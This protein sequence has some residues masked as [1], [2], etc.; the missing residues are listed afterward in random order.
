MSSP[1]PDP[2]QAG[3]AAGWQVIDASTLQQD[4]SFDADVVVIGTGAGGAVVA[5]LLQR[6]GYDQ[7]NRRVE[8]RDYLS[9]AVFNASFTQYDERGLVR[10][11]FQLQETVPTGTAVLSSDPGRET[12][13]GYDILGNK[14]QQ[15]DA[16][17]NHQSW[18]YNTAADGTGQLNFTVGRLNS[19]T[20]TSQAGDLSHATAYAYTDF[21]QISRETY[22]GTDITDPRALNDATQN[23]RR[24]VYKDN[25]LLQQTSDHQMVGKEG[26]DGGLD[27]WTSFSTNTYSYT[28]RGLVSIVDV[29]TTGQYEDYSVYGRVI[30]TYATQEERRHIETGYDNQDRVVLVLNNTNGANNR[31]SSEVRYDYDELGNRT[32]I[33]FDS[34]ARTTQPGGNAVNGE[35]VNDRQLWFKY[36][37]DGRMTLANRTVDAQEGIVKDP[38]VVITYDAAGRRATALTFEGG[39]GLDGPPDQDGQTHEV[40]A[41][42]QSRLERYTYNDLGYLTK[43]EQAGLRTDKRRVDGTVLADDAG[44]SAFQLSETRSYDLLGN[45]ARSDQYYHFAFVSE[46]DMALLPTS[47][48]MTL[49][50]EY[51]TAGLLEVQRTLNP[52]ASWLNTT[53]TNSYENG[54]LRS[55]TYKKGDGFGTNSTTGYTNTYSYGY[56]F[57][58]GALREASIRVVS[59]LRD[60]TV[61][62]KTDTYD[63]RG[64]LVWHRTLD[65]RGNSE[66]TFFYYDGAGRVLDKAQF[67]FSPDRRLLTGDRYDTYFY[68]TGGEAIGDVASSSFAAVNALLHPNFSTS[69]TPVS[70]SYPGSQPGT[71]VVSQG[72]TLAA[73]ARSFL[74]DEQLWYL[75]A[76]A[77]GLSA[78][79]SEAL[80]GHAGRALRIPNVV[81][82][83]HNNAG[84]FSPYNPNTIIPSTPWIGAPLPPPGLTA[85]EQSA[86]SIA[87]IVG[88]AV[89][90]ALGIALG[91]GGAGLGVALSGAIGAAAG[92]V[93]QQAVQL[94]FGGGGKGLDDFDLRAPF[95]AFVKAGVTA[96]VGQFAA[97]IGGST[98]VGQVLARTGG[99]AASYAINGMPDHEHAP[100]EPSN[101]LSWEGLLAAVGA[102]FAPRPADVFVRAAA[103]A[104]TSP[105]GWDWHPDA[106]S[107]GRFY[108]DLAISL[109]RAVLE[110]GFNPKEKGS[111]SEQRTGEEWPWQVAGTIAD[112]RAEFLAAGSGADLA[113]DGTRQTVELSG[114]D[115]SQYSDE[116]LDAMGIRR[117]VRDNKVV[118]L[119]TADDGSEVNLGDP[120]DFV[121]VRDSRTSAS[122]AEGVV[123][124]VAVSVASPMVQS[125]SFGPTLDAPGFDPRMSGLSTNTRGDSV[126]WNAPVFDSVPPAHSSGAPSKLL[127]LTRDVEPLDSI[128]TPLE[129]LPDVIKRNSSR[130]IFW[131]KILIGTE[132][133]DINGRTIDW[134]PLPF[135]DSETEK[136]VKNAAE[137][138]MAKQARNRRLP[139]SSPPPPE[140]PSP[141]PG[142][143]FP[144]LKGVSQKLGT[145]G[146][147]YALP[148]DSRPMP[149][150][151][152]GGSLAVGASIGGKVLGAV[153]AI[154]TIWTAHD[155]AKSINFKEYL[156][157]G[158]LMEDFWFKGVAPFSDGTRVSGR[159]EASAS[160]APGFPVMTI[161]N[162]V[163]GTV[164]KSEG[165]GGVRWDDGMVYRSTFDSHSGFGIEIIVPDK[166]IDRVFTLTRNGISENI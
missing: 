60:S 58:A 161:N 63:G 44:P 71:Y 88:I 25:G 27:F 130:I 23:E 134:A 4:R 77:N 149:K 21:G 154:Q 33:M 51:N 12:A 126:A 54:L 20:S 3:I 95:M 59:N 103:S 28:D 107:W 74:G 37:R 66:L 137:S 43:I 165:F 38:G 57:K 22:S 65:G 127:H 84:T 55:Y 128:W 121:Y 87:P 42:R 155:I 7:A 61:T 110:D 72:D 131:G 133:K 140:G 166:N 6:H 15:T 111:L 112:Y 156:R 123:S 135:R 98:V 76:N 90:V 164:V 73:I 50:N 18:S 144:E 47:V 122:M 146:G 68:S 129:L 34:L 109:G 97:E 31:S 29:N 120:S 142:L 100:G 114:D 113:S 125:P 159:V 2:I 64:N 80:D 148:N 138:E 9:S 106:G 62:D 143:E 102:G 26:A 141:E 163:F 81:A 36:D 117:E 14:V 49:T 78:G 70:A 35:F 11:T 158:Q 30:T 56:A 101:S 94:G 5:V 48:R 13:I 124:A 96:G 139:R 1:I 118:Y 147:S 104:F 105:T 160:M 10:K 39:V 17:G 157:S 99:A 79:P 108:Q 45:L 115:V 116:Q 82:N 75:I 52:Y 150:P 153:N 53:T 145:E 83:I 92:N 85:C 19:I 91:P 93:A 16:W 8:T 152:G 69:F 136:R 46:N 89:A 86:R 32:R 41:W 24:Y 40:A 132:F 67:N 119:T 162:N 151:G